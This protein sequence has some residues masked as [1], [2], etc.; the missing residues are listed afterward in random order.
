[1]KNVKDC[2][3]ILIVGDPGRGKSSLAQFLSTKLSI[4][5]IELDNVFWIKKFTIR[6]NKEDQLQ[7]VKNILQV[8]K[9]WLIEGTTRDMANLCMEDADVIIY[10]RF[11]NI[12]IQL[13]YLLKRGY[14]RREKL[15]PLFELFYTTILKRY[16]LGKGDK[17]KASMKELVARYNHKAIILDSWE[18]INQFRNSLG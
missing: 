4:I 13:I 17:G 8:N 2:K 3:K 9:E 7:M 1:M 11:K 18:S 6:R 5:H 10:M 15:G 12:I 14:E 16:K